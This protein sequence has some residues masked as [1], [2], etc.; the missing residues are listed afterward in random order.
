MK[1][2]F[3]SVRSNSLFGKIVRLIGGSLLNPVKYDHVA[4]LYR[5]NILEAN[6]KYG[7]ELFDYYSYVVNNEVFIH[8]E[9]ELDEAIV[10]EWLDSNKHKKYDWTRTLLWPLRSL[11]KSGRQAKLNCV[12]LCEDIAELHGIAVDREANEHPQEFTER[13]LQYSE[14]T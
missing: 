14:V 7:V 4:I 8:R 10:K 9:I 13:L 11:F 3:V 12:E 2:H 5:G 1:C 6:Y